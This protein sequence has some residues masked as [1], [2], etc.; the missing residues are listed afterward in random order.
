MRREEGATIR[1]TRG[2]R[3]HRLAG[4]RRREWDKG[5]G[6][7]RDRGQDNWVVSARHRGSWAVGEAPEERERSGR[8][9]EGGTD[10]CNPLFFSRCSMTDP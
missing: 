5:E 1:S 2:G 10:S 4:S 7:A 8:R 3:T 9:E 6:R